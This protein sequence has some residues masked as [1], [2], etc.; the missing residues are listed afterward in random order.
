MPSPFEGRAL[1]ACRRV[2]GEDFLAKRIGLDPGSDEH[3]GDDRTGIVEDELP[4]RCCAQVSP[5][6]FRSAS[7]FALRKISLQVS[8]RWTS[9]S[10]GWASPGRSLDRTP[11]RK[12]TDDIPIDPRGF[13]D[14]FRLVPYSL[15]GERL[16]LGETEEPERFVKAQ[17][18]DQQVL[19]F[20]E[21]V[22]VGGR[23]G[24]GDLPCQ[25]C[26]G[27]KSFHYRLL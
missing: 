8:L 25:P 20:N 1:S 18:P 21:G 7:S 9:R 19:P 5:A 11:R 16:D 27:G 23:L 2:L 6:P 14:P 22:P 3:R 12:D 10:A 13:S 17:D 24:G 15:D 26:S 4:S